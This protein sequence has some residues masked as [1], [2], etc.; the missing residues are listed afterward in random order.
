MST[1]RRLTTSSRICLVIYGDGIIICIGGGLLL[2][3]LETHCEHLY[4]GRE[5]TQEQETEEAATTFFER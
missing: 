3:T 2:A 4:G 1:P 5:K